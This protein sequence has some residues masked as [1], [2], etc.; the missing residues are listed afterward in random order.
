MADTGVKTKPRKRGFAAMDE[1]KQRAI[2]S[3]G[4]KASG[5]NFAKDRKKARLAG[6]KGGEVSRRS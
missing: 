5:G 2:A 1:A 3:L 6:K 4:G